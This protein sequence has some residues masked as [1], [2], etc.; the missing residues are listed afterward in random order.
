[1]SDVLPPGTLIPLRLMTLTS[2]RPETTS[3]LTLTLREYG[4]EQV[5][6]Q[7]Q[8]RH[9]CKNA[10]IETCQKLRI[11]THLEVDFDSILG[12]F[13]ERKRLGLVL[14]LFQITREIKSELLA[15]PFE[16]A[17]VHANRHD[18]RGVG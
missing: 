9:T 11:F 5:N 18:D 16:L 3:L 2:L 8:Y 10:G 15:W 1:M 7:G 14:E 17:F 6:E 12:P 4:D 13:F